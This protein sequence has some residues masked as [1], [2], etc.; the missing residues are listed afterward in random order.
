MEHILCEAWIAQREP[1]SVGLRCDLGVRVLCLLGQL[2]TIHSTVLRRWNDHHRFVSAR[3]IHLVVFRPAFGPLFLARPGSSAACS[4]KRRLLARFMAGRFEVGRDPHRLQQRD[5]D[6]GEA[7][8][9]TGQLIE[10]L[11]AA[12]LMVRL[13]VSLEAISRDELILRGTRCLSLSSSGIGYLQQS[14]Q[15]VG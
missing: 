3:E 1:P 11:I 10:Y 2:M 6:S 12:D 9:R 15:G 5:E 13:D 14:L 7:I 4:W 8:R